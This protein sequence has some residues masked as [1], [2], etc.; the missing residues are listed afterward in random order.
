MGLVG[1]ILDVRFFGEKYLKFY[2]GDFQPY[3]LK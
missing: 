3:T 2:G 1:E